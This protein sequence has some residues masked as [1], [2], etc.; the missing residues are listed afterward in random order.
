MLEAGSYV[1]SAQSPSIWPSRSTRQLR[2]LAKAAGLQNIPIC[3]EHGTFRYP[4]AA[5]LVALYMETTPVTAQFTALPE[6]RR[7]AFITG[8]V[9]H[10]AG[11]LDDGL[12][13]PMENHF[14]TASKPHG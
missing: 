6:D 10:R 8:V 4:V 2:S 9:E 5:G 12:A 3:F 7:Q 13:V 14:L 11:Y 1:A